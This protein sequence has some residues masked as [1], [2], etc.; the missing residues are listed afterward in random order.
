MQIFFRAG[1]DRF[2]F[3][4]Q[5][6][7]IC[8]SGCQR[9]FFF[10]HSFETLLFIF[11]FLFDFSNRRIDSVND[12]F[13]VGLSLVAAGYCDSGLCNFFT[14]L[15]EISF[16][17]ITLGQFLFAAS[18]RL[19]DGRLIIRDLFLEIID[20][21]QR[22]FLFLTN[23]GQFSVDLF[24]AALHLLQ[25]TFRIDDLV[26]LG[27]QCVLIGSDLSIDGANIICKGSNAITKLRQAFL[28]VFLL[29]A[30]V[31]DFLFQF[32]DLRFSFKDIRC[33][34]FVFTTCNSA[35]GVDDFAIQRNDFH[36]ACLL[37]NSNGIVHIVHDN[38]PAK[39]IF[40]NVAVLAVVFYTLRS[41]TLE[42][43]F[44]AEVFIS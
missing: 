33:S 25:C 22:V 14:D 38:D 4:N 2:F 13:R 18:L 19:F 41:K 32:C 34:V 10:C 24:A 12:I 15:I 42:S 20:H 31:F 29:R 37:G 7:D 6:I 23:A 11:D 21:T 40:Y 36:A 28:V 16:S 44:T 5:S 8:V 27:D 30:L 26:V 43:G 3:S 35:A 9:S 39:Q 17:F 1:F